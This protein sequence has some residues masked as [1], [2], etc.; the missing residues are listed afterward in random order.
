MRFGLIGVCQKGLDGNTTVDRKQASYVIQGIH[1]M[2]FH[3]L[4]VIT[5]LID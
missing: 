5:G 4:S 2:P 3:G 1:E